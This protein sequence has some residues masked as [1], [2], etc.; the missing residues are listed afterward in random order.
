MAN[1]A[2]RRLIASSYIFICHQVRRITRLLVSYAV[3]VA[4]AASSSDARLVALCP[5]CSLASVRL[6]ASVCLLASRTRLTSSLRHGRAPLPN[7]W[8]PLRAHLASPPRSGS[9]PARAIPALFVRAS[10]HDS[11]VLVPLRPQ[12]A[13]PCTCAA[14]RRR[15]SARVARAV[16]CVLHISPPP[17]R[18]RY[19]PR[20]APGMVYF[21]PRACHPPP[22][23]LLLPLDHTPTS[24]TCAPSAGPP[25]THV[26][27]LTC[28]LNPTAPRHCLRARTP[29]ATASEFAR[30]PRLMT[31]PAA[32]EGKGWQNQH[33]RRAARNKHGVLRIRAAR[34]RPL[35]GVRA[36]IRGEDRQRRRTLPPAADGDTSLGLGAAGQR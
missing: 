34:P 5:L 27:P 6:P 14:P 3:A 23:S 9:H 30:R 10:P 31:M 22:T 32:T 8:L 21:S 18:P 26:L 35:P 16:S 13:I 12:T 20:Q 11:L 2:V 24:L 25:T 7:P 1:P 28:R 29:P 4:V 33:N 15:I 17:R 19:H 36:G